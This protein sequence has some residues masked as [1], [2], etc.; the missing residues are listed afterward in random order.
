MK[1]NWKTEENVQEPG[2]KSKKLKEVRKKWK[3]V[4][5]GGRN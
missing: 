5:N 1:K 2:K 4:Q 3:K